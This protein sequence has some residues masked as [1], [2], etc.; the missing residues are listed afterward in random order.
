M[1]KLADIEGI[2]PI[3]ARML[4]KA[5]ISTTKVLLEQGS[6]P[7]GRKSI[8]EKTGISESLVLKWVNHVELFR[9]IWDR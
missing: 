5:G 6:T 7:K 4:K 1:A 8:A 9:I 3:Y 2:G